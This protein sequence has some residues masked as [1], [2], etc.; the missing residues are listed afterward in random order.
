[1]RPKTAITMRKI[2]QPDGPLEWCGSEVGVGDVVEEVVLLWVAVV[3]VGVALAEVLGSARMARR[4]KI[5]F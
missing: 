1:M 5:M 4:G 3:E 2:T